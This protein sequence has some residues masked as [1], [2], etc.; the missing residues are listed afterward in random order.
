MN[1]AF[2]GFRH[3]HIYTLYDMAEKNDSTHILGCF[4]ENDA[5][6][7]AA[8]NT[9]ELDFCYASYEEILADKRV[10]AVA[11]GDYYGK[12]GK[13]VIDAL[14][15]GKHVIADKPIC[16]SLCELSEI[17]RL[18]KEKGLVVSCML[19]MRYNKHIET[20]SDL[21]SKGTIGKL[22]NISF[23]G[24]HCLDYGNR[25]SWYYEEGKHGGTIND[26]AIHGIDLIRMLT[27][28]NLTKVNCAKVWNGFATKELQFCDCGQFMAEFE[29][30]SVMADVSYAAPKCNV[31][32]PTYWD[33]YF[34]G[35]EGMI[36]FRNSDSAV[37]VYRSC[38]KDVESALPV[39]NN[40]DD[41]ID[42][43]CG[44]SVVFGTAQTLQSQR[45]VLLI[46][47]EADK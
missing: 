11:I 36:N 7:E 5:A 47:K 38:A 18:S 20:V 32:L 6:R 42:E 40:L 15:S 24:Q 8:K 2:A 30:I 27:G 3:G 46:Q 25:P 22:I 37:H 45:Q 34:W 4:E 26:I 1:I 29:D 39:R 31:T 17:E 9:R 14:K 41:F 28:K 33:F 35:T 43:I 21:L 16:T 10:D 19:D 13:M 12:R 44:K 23:T